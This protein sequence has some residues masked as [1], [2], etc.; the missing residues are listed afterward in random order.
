MAK[1]SASQKAMKLLMLIKKAAAIVRAYLVANLPGAAVQAVKE[2]LPQLLKI[3]VTVI[4]IIVFIPIIIIAAIPNIFFG[5]T[6]PFSSDVQQMTDKAAIIKVAYESISELENT[7]SLK[8]GEGL[9]PNIFDIFNN[10]FGFGIIQDLLDTLSFGYD[11]TKTTRTDSD[12]DL[13]WFVAICSAHFAQN[14]FMMEAKDIKDLVVQCF[15]VKSTVEYFVRLNLRPIGR[16]IKLDVRKFGAEELMDILGFDEDKKIWARTI[17][18][19]LEIS[20]TVN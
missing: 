10:G 17:H 7:F 5:F 18:H 9:F 1:S 15:D 13:D 8:F 3:A 14:L 2:F 19:T 20:K 11:D 6:R 12:L 4:I 16:R